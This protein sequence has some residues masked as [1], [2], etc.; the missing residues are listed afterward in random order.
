MKK[1][2]MG[3]F[4]LVALLMTCFTALAG[5]ML[6][7]GISAFLAGPGFEGCEVLSWVQLQGH[8][9]DDC[10]FVLLR[11]TQGTNILLSLIHI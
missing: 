4:L 7:E 8:G 10:C 2:W 9:K 1:R 3:L 6:P 5:D 11:N